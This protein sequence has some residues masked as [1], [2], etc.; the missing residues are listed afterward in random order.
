MGPQFWPIASAALRSF[1]LIAIAMLLIL[2][3]LPAA[4]GAVGTQVASGA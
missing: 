1:V 2:V 4:I 3:L